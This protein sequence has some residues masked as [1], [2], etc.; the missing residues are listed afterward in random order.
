MF[1]IFLASYLISG[2]KVLRSAVIN[3]L[4]GNLFDENFLIA[5][6]TVGAFLIREY[7]EGVAVML[8]YVSVSSSRTWPLTGRGAR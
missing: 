5:V 8:F 3:S 2:W 6:A 1:G 7:P 4:H